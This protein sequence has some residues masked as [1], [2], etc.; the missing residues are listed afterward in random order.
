MLIELSCV[1][2]PAPVPGGVTFCPACEP[3]VLW[4]ARVHR[5]C[6][7]CSGPLSADAVNYCTRCG[8]EVNQ[9]VPVPGPG[10]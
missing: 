7:C 8:T 4:L 9:S 5:E 3:V 6:W 1:R 2:C 10:A